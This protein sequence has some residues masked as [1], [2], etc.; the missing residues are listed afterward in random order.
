[1][2]LDATRDAFRE[3]E[4]TSTLYPVHSMPPKVGAI[5]IAAINSTHVVATPEGRGGHFTV[6]ELAKFPDAE[7]RAIC[8]GA[9]KTVNGAPI[10]IPCSLEAATLE[11]LVRL[12]GTPQELKKAR[13]SHV[14]AYWSSDP[15]NPEE[16]ERLKA[17]HDE[18]AEAYAST[19]SYVEKQALLSQWRAERMTDVRYPFPIA[20]VIGLL[21]NEDSRA[22]DTSR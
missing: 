10:T 12:H 15:L 5:F 11:D 21:T 14:V 6:R 9:Q 19:K 2:A 22:L 8:L 4:D 18:R 17:D 1:M 3:N 7:V 20:N 16:W 13:T